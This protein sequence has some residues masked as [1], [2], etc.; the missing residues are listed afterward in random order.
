MIKVQV[1]YALPEKQKIVDLEISEKSTIQDAIDK[2]GIL[3]YFN[4]SLED[5][6]T[7]IYSKKKDLN[8]ILS[9]GDRVELYR[10]LKNSKKEKTKNDK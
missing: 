1:A 8:T 9:N 4:I 2:S 5:V 6:E 7:G 10:N 3:E